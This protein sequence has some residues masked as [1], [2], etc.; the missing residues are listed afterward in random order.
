MK[1]K[2]LGKKEIM[3]QVKKEWMES[4]EEWKSVE[5]KDVLV[6]QREDKIGEN[7][8]HM[9]R[10]SSFSMND[11]SIRCSERVQTWFLDRELKSV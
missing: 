8:M 10:R 1:M 4:V 11:K 9:S 3:G 7:E 6:V 5:E 2:C